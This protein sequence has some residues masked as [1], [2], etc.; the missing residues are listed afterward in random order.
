MT[1]VDEHVV[2]GA[3]AADCFRVAADVEDWPRILPHYR[4]V[5]FQRKDG[6]GRGRVEMAAWRPFRGPA[7]WPTWWVSEMWCDDEEPAVHYRHVDGL[8]RGMEVVWRFLPEPAG[9][10]VRI[11]H[12]W[13]GP[14]W[15]IIGRLA[16]ERVIGPYF[17]SAIA[18][19]TLAGVAAEVRRRSGR[20]SGGEP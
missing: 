13:P 7:R 8:T 3:A 16:A 14:G 20:G 17:V 11:V 10:R 18:A 6:F 1:T 5:R 2:P 9:T 19:R 12:E 4:W 15:P